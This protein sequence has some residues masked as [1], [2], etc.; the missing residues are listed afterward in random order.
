[1]K[2]AGVC[3]MLAATAVFLIISFCILNTRSSAS[4][5]THYS[6]LTII[7]P[8]TSLEN[9]VISNGKLNINTASAQELVQLPGIG[10]ILA[11][12]IIEYRQKHGYFKSIDQL[13]DV[14]GIGQSK[15]N[16]I[17]AYITVN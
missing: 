10:K 7:S 6:T 11:Q 12:R 16:A 15:L 4:L 3:C 1:M 5:L 17:K 9:N 8:S 13:L 2:K 14:K